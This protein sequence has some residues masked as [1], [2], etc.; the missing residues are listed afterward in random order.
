VNNLLKPYPKP[1][2]DTTGYQAKAIEVAGKIATLDGRCHMEGCNHVRSNEYAI[3]GHHIIH[4]KYKNTCA[5]PE[6]LFP[7]CIPCHTRIH[8]NETEFKAWF[9][10][11]HPGLIEHLWEKAREICHADFAEVYEALLMRYHDALVEKQKAE[12]E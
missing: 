9:E 4:R 2:R 12:S 11:K 3:I 10:S 5:L 8:H 7:C 6:N 1:K